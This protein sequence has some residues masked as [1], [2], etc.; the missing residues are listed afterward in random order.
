M[1]P[2]AFR[3][4]FGDG[5]DHND[6]NRVRD[7]DAIGDHHGKCHADAL[8]PADRH[9]DADPDDNANSFKDGNGGAD[10][11]GHHDRDDHR[12][13]NTD[14][15]IQRNGHSSADPDIDEDA[16]RHAHCKPDAAATVSDANSRA[17][18][19]PIRHR[20]CDENGRRHPHDDVYAYSDAKRDAAT[21]SDSHPHKLADEDGDT[22]NDADSHLDSHPHRKRDENAYGNAHPD[23]DGNSELQ[24]DRNIYAFGN[25]DRQLFADCVADAYFHG[26]SDGDRNGDGFRHGHGD[27][28]ADG[29]RDGD[30]RASRDTPLLN[31]ARW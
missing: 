2:D 29:Q 28:Y 3:K 9:V 7:R 10:R 14:P 30:A 16:E 20:D 17:H 4:C 31:R 11:D 13:R 5:F 12:L 24:F 15:Y 6:P 18:G 1:H 8:R 26:H 27:A 22:N 23:A 19:D 21:H 25:G